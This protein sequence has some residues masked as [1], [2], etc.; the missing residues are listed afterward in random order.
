MGTADENAISDVRRGI[1]ETRDK[2]PSALPQS[3]DE[4]PTIPPHLTDLY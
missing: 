1:E 2:V 3:S 4:L